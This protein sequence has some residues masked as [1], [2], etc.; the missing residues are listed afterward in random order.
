MSDSRAA[1]QLL[2]EAEEQQASDWLA[3]NLLT[4]AAIATVVGDEPIVVGGTAEAY[5]TGRDVYHETDLDLWIA[6][7]IGKPISDALRGLGFKREA[8]HWVRPGLEVVLE[9]PG[10]EFAGAFE[11]LAVEEVAGRRVAVIGLDDLYLD[12]LAQAT[13]TPSEQSVEF[14]SALSVATHRFDDMDWAYVS[15]VIRRAQRAT[16]VLGREL[17]RRNR[18]IRQV[19]RRRLSE[20]TDPLI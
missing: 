12:R 16:P 15:E 4:A 10:G 18:R 20:P 6:G 1:E 2:R 8:R 5:W 17:H 3:A 11:R 19:V 14:M 9:F 7:P 13:A